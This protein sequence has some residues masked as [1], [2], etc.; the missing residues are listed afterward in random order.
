MITHEIIERIEG[1]AGLELE[2]ENNAVKYARI[3][4]LNFR[5]IEKILEKRPPLDALIITPRVCGI[6]CHSHVSASV[7]ALENC[8]ESIGET[9][10]L[11]SKA[12]E[13]REIVQ[14]AEKIQN[15]I[16]WFVFSIL[17]ELLPYDVRL[18]SIEPFRGALWHESQ[19]VFSKAVKMGAIF[20]GQWPHGAYVMVGGV[21]CDP[22]R[23]DVIHARE[24][25]N[26]VDHF[27]KEHLF[28]VKSDIFLEYEN[29]TQLMHS[30]SLLGIA[31]EILSQEPYMYLGQSYDQF[32]VLGKQA[33]M[34]MKKAVKTK[35]VNTDSKY[36]TESLENS[37][38]QKENG[39]TYSKSALY[40]DRYYETGPLAR[41]M[42]QRDNV[43]R[44]LHRRYKD[45][46]LTRIVARV[47]ELAY[48]IVRT[49]KL[50][51]GL[52]IKEDSYIAPKWDINEIKGCGEGII[53]AS[54]GSLIHRV[55]IAYGKIN[56]Y[57]IITPT[58]W[59]LGNGSLHNPAVAQKALIGVKDIKEADLIFKSFDVCSVCTTQ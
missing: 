34:G 50:L 39:Y 5:G 14:N 19:R 29:A 31:M 28:G 20:S 7:T 17:A 56:S 23:S 55:D 43:I 32:I 9:I 24:L 46:I 42:V 3:K 27:C 53:E 52:N 8:Y 44:D 59:N 49:R 1:E 54:R 4:F 48:L 13:I 2:W 25:L 21:T 35:V 22:V 10:E 38:F 16:K 58:V 57:D 11:T 6:C 51:E 30:Q 36:V 47:R 18:A 12:M 26:E 41:M 33:N 45:S 15:H 40:K 37:F